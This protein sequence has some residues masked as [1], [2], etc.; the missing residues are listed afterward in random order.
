MSI[1]AG[2][3]LQVLGGNQGQ[4]NKPYCFGGLWPTIGMKVYHDWH[5]GF[6]LVS[7]YLLGKRLCYYEDNQ[8]NSNWKK[9]ILTH[10]HIYIYS[11]YN[12]NHIYLF[13]MLYGFIFKI[14]FIIQYLYKVCTCTY[15]H[16][17]TYICILK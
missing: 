13:Y 2:S 9:Y 6:C 4:C 11:L 12:I 7:T 17:Y 14:I 1:E 5:Q 8:G 10:I 3:Y 15:T 16:K